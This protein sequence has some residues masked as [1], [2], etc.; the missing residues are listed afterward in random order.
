LLRLLADSGPTFFVANFSVE[1][2]PDEATQ[3]MGN[4]ADGS[5]VSQA[6]NRTPIHNFEDASF[7][8]YRG[9]G[10]LIE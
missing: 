4:G 10:T 5:I 6:R 2:Q 3:S 7:G 8:F 1:D 9:V